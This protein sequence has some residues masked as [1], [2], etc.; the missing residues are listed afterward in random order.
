L[1]RAVEEAIPQVPFA[2]P[3]LLHEQV[4]QMYNW[5]SV[6]Q[7]TEHVYDKISQRKPE[8][9]IRR[10]RRYYSCGAVAGKLFCCL[11]T[12]FFL[13]WSFWDWFYPASE[14]D[15]APTFPY[16]EYFAMQKNQAEKSSDE[17]E[18]QEIK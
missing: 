13:W 6:A 9:L 11:I 18:K 2:Q 8:P 17:C 1:E 4:K 14:I 7:R 12:I 5:H 15:I 10:F 16:Q 3:Y